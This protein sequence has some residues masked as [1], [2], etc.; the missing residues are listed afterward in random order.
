MVTQP[1]QY[2]ITSRADTDF[3]K[4]C[5]G[6]GAPL[7]FLEEIRITGQSDR[8]AA[9]AETQHMLALCKCLPLIQSDEAGLVVGREFDD[10]PAVADL[11]RPGR[12]CDFVGY[13]VAQ[14]HVVALQQR[15]WVL[16]CQS[17]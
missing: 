17:E 12:L 11:R 4:A 13:G 3:A 7:S 1:N 6:E 5:I 15:A 10:N 16:G 14:C 9:S 8:F 2:R